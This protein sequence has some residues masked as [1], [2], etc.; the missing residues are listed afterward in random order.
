[1]AEYFL[2]DVHLRLDQP[3]R[4]ERLARLVDG[5]RADDRLT[6]VGDL[7]DFWFAARQRRGDPAR[8]A[9]L[10]SLIRFRGRGGAIT[11]LAGNHD[12]SLGPYYESTLG[13][14][15]VPDRLEREVEGRR[16]LIAHGHRLG[17]RTPW[18]AAMEGRAF[19]EVFR[20]LPDAIAGR[21]DQQLART[22]GRHQV[23]FDRRG[24]D[25]FRRLVAPMRD[26][27]D[28]VILGHVH[29]P[30]DTAPDRPRLVV[31]GGWHD[32]SAYLVA[33]GGEARHVLEPGP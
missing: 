22:N 9:G 18:K 10:R 3:E 21:L 16:T 13:A 19:L 25:T 26:R 7:C 8:C 29:R 30:L 20:R 24:L 27:Y 1:M 12:A 17:A 32:G 2:S 31:L 28:L 6:I 11:V 5:L 15:F 14:T 23:E 4:G 33:D